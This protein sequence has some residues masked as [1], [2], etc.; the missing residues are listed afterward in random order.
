MILVLA[1]VFGSF[2]LLSLR[3]A[4]TEFTC[5]EGRL[6]SELLAVMKALHGGFVWPI[7]DLRHCYTVYWL[8]GF[9]LPALACLGGGT[10]T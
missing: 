6:L 7:L 1:R 10:A 8:A 5:P 9:F 3:K 2:R 4:V